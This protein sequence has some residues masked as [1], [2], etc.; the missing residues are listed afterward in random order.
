MTL[1]RGDVILVLICINVFNSQYKFY[2]YTSSGQSLMMKSIKS[3]F[4]FVFEPV[5]LIDLTNG[6]YYYTI[7][8]NNSVEFT[9][10]LVVV[11]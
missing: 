10:K 1:Q 9:G 8:K 2:L 5:E 7:S 3:N 4:G 11:E 6:V